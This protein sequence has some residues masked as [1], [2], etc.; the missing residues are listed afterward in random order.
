MCGG[1]PY[2]PEDPKLKDG[3]FMRPCVLGMSSSCL[4]L[5]RLNEIA[6]GRE[7]LYSMCKVASEGWQ[8]ACPHHSDFGSGSSPIPSLPMRLPRGEQ[9]CPATRTHWVSPLVPE[10]ELERKVHIDKKY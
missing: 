1:D 6:D 3:Y 5:N 9:V 7:F 8:M 10:V 2:V 4:L